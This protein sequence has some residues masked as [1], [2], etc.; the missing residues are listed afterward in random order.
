MKT[1]PFNQ[2]LDTDL[3][4]DC[5]CE[6]GSAGT[7]GDEPITKIFPVG[8]Q[9]GFR[10]S[11]T[12]KK[13]K[14]LVLFTDGS[15]PDWPDYLDVEAGIFTY[16]GDQRTP[17]R[18]LHDTKLKGNFILREIF[19]LLYKGKEGRDLIPPIFLFQKYPTDY[20]GWSRQFRG[21]LVPGTEKKNSQDDLVALWRSMD[22]NR[23]LNYRA[24]FTVLNAPVI[25]RAWI[26]SVVSGKEDKG[27]APKSWTSWKK[28][29]KAN[30]LKARRT[31]E[32]RSKESQLPI[33]K[34][35]QNLLGVLVKHFEDRP[36]AFEKLA[37]DIYRMSDSNVV[38]DTVT[39]G[40]IDGGRDAIGRF[41]LGLK[42]DP[43]YVDFVLEAK[44]YNP[45]IFQGTLNSVGVRE[46]S[47]L[48]S[49]IKH[50]Q[51]GVMVTTSVIAKQAYSE[52]REDQHPIVFISGGDIIDVL[53]TS[54]IGI[55]S[56]LRDFLSSY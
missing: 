46:V 6:G 31:V 17:G 44:C 28:T 55:E 41:K 12:A 47:R 19:N 45:G 39:R 4:V 36:V 52:V 9:G 11:G 24:M 30:I 35:D 53:K 20:S 15:Q 22:G 2:L 10:F 42:S 5:I 7:F 51:F 1:I 29:G 32:I 16:F 34:H 50:R 13:P 40:V 14:V 37:A 49:R 21:L 56:D 27:L 25:S 48:I 33:T 38:I 18:E 26:N 3:T 54:G 8:T 23:F 43:V